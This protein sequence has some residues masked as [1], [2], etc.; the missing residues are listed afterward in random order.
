[1]NRNPVRVLHRHEQRDSAKPL[2]PRQELYAQGL[3]QGMSQ[4]AAYR[5]AGYKGAQA[6]QRMKKYPNIQARVAQLMDETA[7]RSKISIDEIT[8]RLLEIVS[9]GEV[10]DSAALLQLARQALMDLA[11]I[12][13][14]LGERQGVSGPSGAPLEITQIRRIIVEPDGTHWEG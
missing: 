13:G 11:K 5:A 8:Q 7:A 1:M 4:A 12:H 3:S 14:L 2:N 6:T 10:G 9:R